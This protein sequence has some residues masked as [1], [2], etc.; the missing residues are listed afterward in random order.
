MSIEELEEVV[1]KTMMKVDK[2]RVLL[3][4]EVGT[5]IAI[6]AE[7]DGSWGNFDLVELDEASASEWLY[8]LDKIGVVATCKVLLAYINWK[9]NGRD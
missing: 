3:E 7:I 1:G 5:G 9:R 6:R 2:R 8:G 4:K